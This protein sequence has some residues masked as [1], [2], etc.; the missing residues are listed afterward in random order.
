MRTAL[1]NS[2]AQPMEKQAYAMIQQLTVPQR[3]RLLWKLQAEVRAASLA[4][5][6][7]AP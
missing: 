4:V 7:S 2:P 3:D 6:G 5:V 1:P